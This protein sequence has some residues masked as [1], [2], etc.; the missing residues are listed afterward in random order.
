MANK[1]ETHVLR[2]ETS[3]A[4]ILGDPMPNYAK[5]GRE[6]KMDLVIKDKDTLKEVKGLGIGDRVKNK[7]NYL[8]GAPFL[9]F[10]QAEMRKDG[11][12]PNQPITVVDAAGNPWPDSK[13]IGNGSTVDVKF[14]VMDYGPGKKKGVYIRGVRVLDLVPYEP[15]EFDDLDEDDEF[16][17]AAK[18]AEEI[19]EQRE[20][21]V[22][23]LSG[24]KSDKSGSF[25]SDDPL[26]DDLDDVL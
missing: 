6:W 9:T 24:T 17:K 3:Y 7:E 11:V 13:L 1:T 10:K 23:M 22:A 26:D 19:R 15:K 8:D 2:G 14:V 20:K 18:E 16:Y 25:A 21:D 5:D 12:T 4:K